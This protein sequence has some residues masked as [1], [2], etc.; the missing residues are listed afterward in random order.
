VA[1][2]ADCHSHSLPS[3]VLESIAVGKPVLCLTSHGSTLERLIRACGM[4]WSFEP[5]EYELMAGQLRRLIRGE[6][7]LP[8]EPVPGT[9]DLYTVE[10]TVRAFAEVLQRAAG[11]PAG[12][13]DVDGPHAPQAGPG[14]PSGQDPL[15]PSQ[16]SQGSGATGSNNL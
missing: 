1:I 11:R 3:K 9:M 10:A 12:A 4:G 8:T 2:Q 14:S 6:D 16:V 15:A 7:R 13:R 5:S